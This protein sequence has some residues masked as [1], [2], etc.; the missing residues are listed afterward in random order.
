MPSRIQRKRVRGWRMPEGALYVG[1]PSLWGNPWSDRDVCPDRTKLQIAT[2]CVD[3]YRED[4]ETFSLLTDYSLR[5]S[6][7]R[8]RRVS[9]EIRG[10][11]FQSMREAAVLLR[12]Y[13]LACWC[14]LTDADGNPWPC[15]ADVL[16][17]ICAATEGGDDATRA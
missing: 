1:R 15:H 10:R 9:A 11:G 6:E 4:L 14:P 5:V 3:R 17:E 16:L 12:G 7:Q 8:W 2:F 13:D